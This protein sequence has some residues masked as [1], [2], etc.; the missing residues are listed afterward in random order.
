MGHQKPGG[1][2]RQG[3]HEEIGDPKI[4]PSETW[5][6]Y[7]ADPFGFV[8]TLDLRFHGIQFNLF[9]KSRTLARNMLIF[10]LV[11]GG[12]WALFGFDSS[13]LQLVHVLYEGIPGWIQGQKTVGDLFQIF[14]FYYGKEMHYSAFVIYG[15]T[16]WALSVHYDQ[17]LTWWFKDFQYRHRPGGEGIPPGPATGLG[18]SKSK[19]VVFASVIT[20]LSGGIFETF[21]ILSFSYFQG[22]TWIS[23]FHGAQI[24]IVLQNM[25]F[26]FA[27]GLGLLYMWA[28][29]YL[30]DGAVLKRRWKFNWS[31]TSGILLVLTA[32]LVL[33]W[34]FYP[35]PTQTVTV[36]LNNGQTW[37][38][39]PL[40]PQTLYTIETTPG[41][42]AGSWYYVQDDAV[43]LVNS[44]VKVFMA[45][46]VGSICLLRK[47]DKNGKL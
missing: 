7:K 38:S 23:S 21:W 17:G 12:L 28:D 25:I 24:R 6:K 33:L 31:R 27:G 18:I 46:A 2:D 14:N 40:F 39:S 30:L 8:D 42:G 11:M 29:G 34:W 19:N 37:V 47:V 13:P 4:K 16:F 10:S 5:Q 15:L 41:S 22:Q 1:K 43:H 20:L 35:F 32:A 3:S 9:T 36:P 45:M 26:L 44:L